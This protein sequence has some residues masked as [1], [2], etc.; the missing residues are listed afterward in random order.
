MTTMSKRILFMVIVLHCLLRGA[1]LHALDSVKSIQKLSQTTG[2]DLKPGNQQEALDL[3]A[4]WERIEDLKLDELSLLDQF[5]TYIVSALGIPLKAPPPLDGKRISRLDDRSRTSWYKSLTAAQKKGFNYFNES[6]QYF[7]E[8]P[9]KALKLIEKCLE[10]FPEFHDAVK[11]R[12][13]LRYELNK[14]GAKEPANFKRR[15]LAKEL[16]S[17]SS[18]I[19]FLDPEQALDLVERAIKKDPS[20]REAYSERDL[21]KYFLANGKHPPEVDPEEIAERYF[22]QGFEMQDHKP[23]KAM[24]MMRA[25]LDINSNHQNAI[26]LLSTLEKSTAMKLFNKGASLIEKDFDSGF[27]FTEEA[28]KLMP[29]NLEFNSFMAK[30]AKKLYRRGNKIIKKSP[31]LAFALIRKSVKYAQPKNSK[32]EVVLENLREKLITEKLKAVSDLFEQRDPDEFEIINIINEIEDMDAQNKKFLSKKLDFADKL[33][34]YAKYY[35]TDDHRRAMQIII[36][37]LELNPSL[38]IASKDFNKLLLI[39]AKYLGDEANTI[40]SRFLENLTQEDFRSLSSNL[41]ILLT[42]NSEFK[43]VKISINFVDELFKNIR[44][45]AGDI[46]PLNAKVAYKLLQLFNLRYPDHIQSQVEM[47]KLSELVANQYHQEA[48]ELYGGNNNRA[49]ELLLYGL[50]FDPENSSILRDIDFLKSDMG[51]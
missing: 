13:I 44:N 18:G 14:P 50:D 47:N 23:D 40:V 28:I 17:E 41:W 19:S 48:V 43:N 6:N 4:V 21:L 3:W 25:T 29:D 27:K 42:Q 38:V 31:E 10:L 49:L 12:E 9:E 32:Y 51:L 34:S 30:H 36:K 33:H 45:L 46:A 8:D 35:F 24:R 7:D 39:E 5:V 26:E 15:R 37:V 22:S 16:I 2:V 20:Y 11:D 1:K